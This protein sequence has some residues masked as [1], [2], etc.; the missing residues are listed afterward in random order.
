MASKVP[1]LLAMFMN[2]LHTYSI[3]ERKPRDYGI[4]TRLTLSEVQTL[5]RIGEQPGINLTGLADTMGVT[6]GAISQMIHK[7][8]S[9][10]LVIK[11]KNRNKKEYNLTLT[12]TGRKA[13]DN[14]QATRDEIFTFAQAL[15]DQATPH[16]RETVRRLFL[17]IQTNLKERLTK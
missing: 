12:E 16:D 8:T 1:D 13:Y 10:K 15:Y 5:A 6:R 3:I 14:N 9:K 4:G 7:L 11:E 2:I 17:A